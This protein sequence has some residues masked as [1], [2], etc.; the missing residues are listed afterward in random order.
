MSSYDYSKIMKI[1]WNFKGANT[2]YLTHNYHSY[3]ARFIPQIPRTVI[4]NFTQRGEV[5]LDPF[6]GCG[7]TLVE[8]VLMGRRTIGI[9]I[10]P[11]AC[12]IAKVKTTPLEPNTL[13]SYAT[14]LINSITSDIMLFRGRKTLFPEPVKV[15]S[16]KMPPMPNRK[17]STKFSPQIKR[18]LA[19][20]KAN[21]MEIEDEDIKD[22][23][24]VALSSTIRA[25]VESRRGAIDVLNTFSR[26]VKMMV[27]RMK[28]FYFAC[29]KDVLPARIYCTDFRKAYFLETHSVDL[30]VTSPPYVNAYDYHREH[31]FNI[32]W[33]HDYLYNKFHIDFETFKRNELGAHSHNIYNRFKTVGEYFEGIY[34]CFQQM[35]RILKPG[36]VCCVVIGD[37]T[38]EGELIRT[39]QYFKEIGEEVGLK[40]RVDILRDIDIER[41]YLSKTIGKINKEHVLI[42]E[43]ISDDWEKADPINYV[44]SLLTRL[45]K[46]CK[47]ENRIKIEEALKNYN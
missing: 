10:N 40:I 25:V 3:P 20:I 17:L 29:H 8:A 4:E 36:K 39:H 42:F 37:S 23:F 46:D 7:T 1:D 14:R 27:S 45:L 32:L 11:L 22:F 41:K 12:L 38:V 9:D 47:P 31:M 15:Q 18:E 2:T 21:I 13:Q 34:R 24:M 35:S 6:C 28:E 30:I 44:R 16:L 43:K 33:L 19:C 5:V 26:N